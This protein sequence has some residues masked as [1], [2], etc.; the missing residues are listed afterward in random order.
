MTMV[1]AQRKVY[2]TLKPLGKQCINK[3]GK[4]IKPGKNTWVGKWKDWQNKNQGMVNSLKASMKFI[5]GPA[6]K[7]KNINFIKDW[8]LGSSIWRQIL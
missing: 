1:E 8:L 4:H 2:D 6:W 7:A 3:L 5:L